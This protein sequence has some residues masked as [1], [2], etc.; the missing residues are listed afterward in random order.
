MIIFARRNLKLFFR[1]RAAV[2]FSLLAVLIIIGLYVLFLGDMVAGDLTGVPGGRFLMDSW[3]MA[4]LL[5]V[6]SVTTTMGAVGVVVD[7][8]SKGIAKDFHAS[9]LKRTTLVGGYLLSTMAIGVIMSIVGLI[10]AELYILAGGGEFLPLG[11]LLKVLGL[12]FL[13]TMASGSLVFFLA[14]FFKTQNAYGVA[15]TVVGTLI[16][17]LMGIYVPIGVLPSAVQTAIRLFPISHA[18]VLFRQV[19]MDVPLDR[20]FAEAPPAMVTNFKA[21]LGIVFQ[22]GDSALSTAGSLLVLVV[23]TVIFFALGVWRM[24]LPEKK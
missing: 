24:L 7:D 2:F 17:F 10:L 9:P 6:T 14:S 1:D 13:S 11:N 22:F 23:T 19:L 15:S 8:R 16:G 20:S 12:I 18:A 3:I 21:S 5:A 4:G